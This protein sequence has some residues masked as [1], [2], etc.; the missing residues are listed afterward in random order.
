MSSKIISNIFHPTFILARSVACGLPASMWRV[1]LRGQQRQHNREDLQ[2]FPWSFAKFIEFIVF[3][4]MHAIIWWGWLCLSV[5]SKWWVGIAGM[6]LGASLF[7]GVGLSNFDSK[8]ESSFFFWVYENVMIVHSIKYYINKIHMKLKSCIAYY[9][10][11]TWPH[12]FFGFLY[13]MN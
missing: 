10:L 3:P 11:F 2:L 9:F 7:F 5:C 6:E 8:T 12:Y 1:F 13:F 4:M